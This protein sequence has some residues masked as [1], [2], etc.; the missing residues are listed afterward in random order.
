MPRP[1]IPSVLDGPLSAEQES[2]IWQAVMGQPFAM[3]QPLTGWLLLSMSVWR[4]KRALSARL[5]EALGISHKTWEAGFPKKPAKFRRALESFDRHIHTTLA[6]ATPECA[7]RRERALKRAVQSFSEDPTVVPC[8]FF[9]QTLGIAGGDALEALA[10]RIDEISSAVLKHSRRPDEISSLIVDA[11][12]QAGEVPAGSVAVALDLDPGLDATLMVMARLDR[13]RAAE[14]F[15]DDDKICSLFGL[16][17]DMSHPN[18]GRS[19]RHRLLDLYYA[20]AIMADGLSLPN[21]A[22]PIR[23]L[24]NTLLGGPPE[25]GGQSWIV[26]W[27]T[28]GKNIRFEDLEEIGAYVA[29]KTLNDVSD[30]FRHLGL[31]AQFWEMVELGGPVAVRRAGE[32]YRVWWDAMDS[33]GRKEIILPEPYWKIFQ[34]H[35]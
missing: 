34:P 14:L 3:A 16:L 30:I 7:Q 28:K 33:P 17:V 21:L 6:Q 20:M 26:R 2:A 11:A 9:H 35:A 8:A 1:L 4:D 29:K 23:D 5:A 10:V 18:S 27:R 13:D 25:S 12:V 22:P 31:I 32:R 15:R 19:A 24:E